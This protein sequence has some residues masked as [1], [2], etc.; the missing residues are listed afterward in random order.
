MRAPRELCRQ[1]GNFGPWAAPSQPLR[2]SHQGSI[3]MPGR[4]MARA[5]ESPGSVHAQRQ[6]RCCC[7]GA[8]MRQPI[9]V[10]SCSLFQ[11]SHHRTSSPRCGYSALSAAA[12]A[13]RATPSCSTRRPPWPRGPS[14][15]NSSPRSGR[16]GPN[17]CGYRASLISRASRQQRPT[18][19]HSAESIHGGSGRWRP[20]CGG[21]GPWWVHWLACRNRMC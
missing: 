15:R 19:R 13:N 3:T 6:A 17:C 18:S 9:C 21:W 12:A 2:P 11:V 16:C 1:V 7:S 4:I 10:P 5:S 20:G 14:P 8:G